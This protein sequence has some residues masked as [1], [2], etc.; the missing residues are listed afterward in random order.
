MCTRES[1]NNFGEFQD[2]LWSLST[3]KTP[4]PSLQ[5][6]PTWKPGAPT[7]SSAAP[8]HVCRHSEKQGA[9]NLT[10]QHPTCQ[11]QGPG[12]TCLLQMHPGEPRAPATAKGKGQNG[13]HLHR[14]IKKWPFGCSNSTFYIF[15]TFTQRQIVCRCWVTQGLPHA[16]QGTSHHFNPIAAGALAAATSLKSTSSV[17]ETRRSLEELPR[18]GRARQ[19]SE[20]R[21]FLYHYLA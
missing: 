3:K 12:R 8:T 5:G 7:M 20:T 18:P 4:C 14:D 9:R 11:S 19:G 15:I 2:S 13:L 21:V 17:R 10:L 16:G 1:E 6:S